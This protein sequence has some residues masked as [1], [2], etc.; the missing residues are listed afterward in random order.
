MTDNSIWSAN[1]APV[2]AHLAREQLWLASGGQTG[3]IGPE[4][5][6]VV[7]QENPDGTVRILPGGFSIAATSPRAAIGYT[8]APW[9]SYGRSLYDPVTVEISPTS[10]AGGR[11]DVVGIVIHDPD[12]EG[13]ELEGEELAAHQ[14]W[15]PHVVQN[16]G[17]NATRP[18][19]FASLRRPF[20]PLAQIRIPASTGTI[21]DAMIH[22]IRFLAVAR[23]HAEELI[24]DLSETSHRSIPASQTAWTTVASFEGIQQPQWATIVKVAMMLGPVYALDDSVNGQ[25]RVRTTGPSGNP[26]STAP[27][28]FV[29][30][31]QGAS[32]RFYMHAA[33]VINLGATAAGGLGNFE[34]QIRRTNTSARTGRLIIPSN[35][36]Q[37]C[38]AVGR[39]TY[40]ETPRRRSSG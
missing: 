31:L 19:H 37:V 20:L 28:L 29:E 10:S 21:T 27:S 13:L 15:R 24:Q 30:T 17:N 8:S 33:G 5:C 36:T 12:F 22:D 23:T 7:A 26:V 34:L 4:S 32:E 40:E 14:F 16:A 2:P 11:T 38:R 9:Q 3:V 1:G 39:L 25:F 35:D 6:E 18:E